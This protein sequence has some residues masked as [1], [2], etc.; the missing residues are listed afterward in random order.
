LPNQA[1]SRPHQ[2]VFRSASLRPIKRI[3]Q[4]R[5]AALLILGVE[6]QDAIDERD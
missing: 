4:T 1:A 6:D 5:Q 3:E 2:Q